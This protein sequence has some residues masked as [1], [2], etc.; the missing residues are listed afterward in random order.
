MDTGR[1]ST[2]PGRVG[3]N[4]WV[5]VELGGQV[6]VPWFRGAVR[7][8]QHAEQ[9][10]ND[11]PGMPADRSGRAAQRRY[12]S[13]HHRLQNGLLISASTSPRLTPMSRSIRSSS[14]ANWAR[15]RLRRRHSR[16]TAIANKPHVFGSRRHST[17]RP[18][19]GSDGYAPG[20][21]G[22]GQTVLILQLPK[23]L[24]TRS[25]RIFLISFRRYV[26]N[27]RKC[28]YPVVAVPFAC[29]TDP[30]VS[31]GTLAVV[32]VP[33]EASRA[34]SRSI[35]CQVREPASRA[36]RPE[37]SLQKIAAEPV[38]VK[39]LKTRAKQSTEDF[40]PEPMAG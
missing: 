26:R 3:S 17:R 23:H 21:D 14:N 32:T 38:G 11:P 33:T 5:F 24:D 28:L 15:S 12:D 35:A 1:L 16:N 31:P 7:L 10:P 13:R 27:D 36:G 19:R 20:A 30:K 39:E 18:R 4:R 2:D 8:R 40:V 22:Q 37:M 29:R 25:D 9:P 34:A 6:G